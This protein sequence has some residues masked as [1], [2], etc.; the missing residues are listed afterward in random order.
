[1]RWFFAIAAALGT[2]GL[3]AVFAQEPATIGGISPRY[4]FE[5]DPSGG[6]SRTIFETDENSN[7]KIIIRD[8]AFPPDRQRHSLALPSD[9]FMHLL[10]GEGE[11]TVARSK[12]DL[13]PG[14][15]RAVPANAPIEVVN[16]SEYPLVIRLLILEAK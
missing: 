15:R 14:A 10:S 2:A 8:F 7:F 11:I 9:A 3:T 4:P 5:T 1:M 6:F 12:L 16:T 13:I